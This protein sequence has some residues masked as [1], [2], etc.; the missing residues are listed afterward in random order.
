VHP[1]VDRGHVV[2]HVAVAQRGHGEIGYLASSTAAASTS[3]YDAGRLS[4][5]LALR[6]IIPAHEPKA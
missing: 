6:E 1:T 2:G 4:P 3:S 5:A